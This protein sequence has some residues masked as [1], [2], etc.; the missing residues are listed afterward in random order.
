[1]RI[2]SIGVV[3]LS[4][5]GFCVIS[6]TARAES[7]ED[8]EGDVAPSVPA[9]PLVP[10][11]PVVARA[12]WARVRQPRPW[13]GHEVLIADAVTASLT[14]L[15]LGLANANKDPHGQVAVLGFSS[16]VLS[17]PIIHGVHERWGMATASL[18]LRFFTPLVGL[19]VGAST[20]TCPQNEGGD[21]AF[22][23]SAAA[24][25]AGL[26]GGMVLASAIDAALFSYENRKPEIE[27]AAR[28]GIAPAF[29]VAGR[30]GE[31]R[32]FGTF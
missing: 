17:A 7:W 10:T 23:G 8:P 11:Q 14:G 20:G 9:S 29:S 25:D 6:G 22:C 32:A 13:Y 27:A 4:C 28:F 5:L 18:S 16:Y 1:M 15:G 21:V 19:L 3:G 31:L 26:L 30:S 12:Q 24:V 2:R